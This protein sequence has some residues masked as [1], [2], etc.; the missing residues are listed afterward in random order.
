MA[1][2]S[3]MARGPDPPI[4]VLTESHVAKTVSTSTNV[5][6]VSMTKA[7]PAR[8]P[9]PGVVKPSLSL[10]PLTEMSWR[11]QAPARAPADWTT[12]Y[13]SALCTHAVQST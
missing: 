8:T 11:I 10:V 4:P 9:A 13:N 3:P 12:M 5:I 1:M 7:C 2:E 6:M